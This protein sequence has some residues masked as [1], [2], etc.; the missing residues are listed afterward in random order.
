MDILENLAVGFGAVLTPYHLFFIFLGQLI[1]I[2]VGIL[3]G[4]NSSMAVATLLPLTFGLAAQPSLLLLTGI[5]MGSMFGGSITSI[6]MRVPGTSTAAVVCLDGYEMTCQGKAGCA[7]GITALGSWVAGTFSLIVL[8]SVG[9]LLSRYALSFGPT[10]Y[11]A[12]VFL[13]LA[14]ITSLG[15]ASMV[16]GLISGTLGLLIG[17]IGIDPVTGVNR[18]TFGQVELLNGVD[19]IAVLIG[20]FAVSQALANLE[21]NPGTLCNANSLSGLL[22]SWTE[23]KQSLSSILRGSVLGTF[24]GILPGAG[25]TTAAFLSYSLEAQLAKDKKSVG[26]GNIACV[27]GPGSADNAAAGGALIPLLS[28]GIPGSETTAVLIGALMIHGIRPGPLLFSEHGSLV[29]SIIASLYIAN[30]LGLFLATAGVKP[31]TIILRLPVA[32]MSAFI[33]VMSFVGGYALNNS[34]AE[35]WIVLVSGVAGYLMRRLDVPPAPLILGLVLGPLAEKSFRQSLFM[36]DGS[37]SIFLE[38]PIALAFLIAGI[39]SLLLPFLLAR[40]QQGTPQTCE[41]NFAE[42]EEKR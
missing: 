21:K 34:M 30:C 20:L 32:A 8:M 28:M 14:T 38:R 39:V 17:T 42:M 22:P 3:P 13:G 35:V 6:L 18:F 16:K 27:A 10:E 36:S 33:L 9:P 2:S 5:Y 19:F 7:L 37:L 26:K 29:W 4:I 24:V 1:G 12:L 23:I 40:L 25:A 15:S 11:F 41:M 31:L